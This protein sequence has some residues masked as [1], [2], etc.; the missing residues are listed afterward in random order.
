MPIWLRT[1]TYNFIADHKQKEKESYSKTP[2]GNNKKLDFN[3]PK[4]A[5]NIINQ[6]SPSYV[7]KASKK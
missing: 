1:L 3:N 6:T 5:K 2:N 4:E 7:T